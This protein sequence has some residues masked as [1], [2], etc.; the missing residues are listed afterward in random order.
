MPQALTPISPRTPWRFFL[1]GSI[2]RKF[3]RTYFESCFSG[4]P[5]DL[6]TGG[7][8]SEANLLLESLRLEAELRF[9][10]PGFGI[11]HISIIFA[12]AG[13]YGASNADAGNGVKMRSG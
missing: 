8:D 12:P 11:S 6:K 4:L 9:S 3:V 7:T 10:S 5:N 13:I 1:C 2:Q